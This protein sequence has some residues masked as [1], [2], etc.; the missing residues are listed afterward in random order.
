MQAGV[1]S[2][3]QL[4]VLVGKEATRGAAQAQHRTQ[5]HPDLLT[6]QTLATDAGRS[7]L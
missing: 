2:F 7:G 3:Q 6:Q 4:F 1:V 5:V